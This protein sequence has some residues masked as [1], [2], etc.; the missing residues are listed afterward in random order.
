[1]DNQLNEYDF[2]SNITDV[3]EESSFLLV[4]LLRNYFCAVFYNYCQ[5][6]FSFKQN[7]MEKMYYLSTGIPT[8]SVLFVRCLFLVFV[9]MASEVMISPRTLLFLKQTPFYFCHFIYEI[10]SQ[11][12]RVLKSK[13][14]KHINSFIAYNFRRWKGSE[15]VNKH[16]PHS[17]KVFCT[18]TVQDVGT[19]ALKYVTW[20]SLRYSW[21][22]LGS[23]TQHIDASLI[24]SRNN[25][26]VSC[27]FGWEDEVL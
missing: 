12:I 16:I 14:M 10:L 15:I 2:D 8:C 19:A 22:Q 11:Q 25:R 6:L 18:F 1:M 3:R 26:L 20:I 27:S 7:E 4:F 23:M 24:M 9:V 5:F 21:K 17:M 13:A